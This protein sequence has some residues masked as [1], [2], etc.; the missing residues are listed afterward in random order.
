MKLMAGASM[1]KSQGCLLYLPG[2][3]DAK[4]EER[5][6][7]QK[8]KQYSFLSRT[9]GLHSPNLYIEVISPSRIAFT[10]KAERGEGRIEQLA[11]HRPREL[12]Q[13]YLQFRLVASR[14]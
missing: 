5:R 9:E 12:T 1:S 14:L 2:S 3:Q 8:L 10:S 11:I 7:N 13:W 4:G 6:G